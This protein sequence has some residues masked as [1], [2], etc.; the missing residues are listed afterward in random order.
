MKVLALMLLLV[1][2]TAAQWQGGRPTRTDAPPSGGL[3]SGQIG[4]RSV[5]IEDH[6]LSVCT[7]C[8]IGSDAQQEQ[9]GQAYF[10][11]NF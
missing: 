10:L 6:M 2:V 4:G 8:T 11:P 5:Q 7:I 3:M 1:A 9:I